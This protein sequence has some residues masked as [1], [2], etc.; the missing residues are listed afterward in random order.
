MSQH[1]ARCF[2]CGESNFRHWSKA[3]DVEYFTTDKTF[4]FKECLNCKLLMIDP[5]PADQ[6]H[7]IYPPNYYSFIEPKKSIVNN[8]KEWLDKRRF[9]HI[10]NRLKSE[11][12][13]VLDV[14][15]GS[16]WL[17][18]FVRSLSGRVKE[19]YV[20]D[21]DKNA[22][23]LAIQ[24]GHKYFRGRIEDFET[25]EKFDFVL[26]LNLIEHVSDPLAVMKK[27]SDILTPDGVLL[28][29]TPNYDSLDARLYRHK[30][31]GGYHCPRHWVLFGKDSFQKLA[32]A[33]ELKIT[34]FTYTQGAP[35]WAV[36]ILTSLHRRGLV[37]LSAA[38]PAFM[39]PLF[40]PILGVFGAFD[41]LRV[42]FSK[43]S[44]MFITLSKENS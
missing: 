35:F 3:T 19:T 17:L 6:L 23:S 29:K 4:Y 32:V 37:K 44:Q 30:N 24:N 21:I 7:E 15:G 25:T 16:G 11:H 2:L 39:H 34:E 5:V 18:N 38:R 22:E 31:W 12:L 28:I 14:G 10:L 8:I 36:S 20:V 27:I 41:L 9:K 43:T 13:K 40:A 26:L 1:V 33:A 42:P